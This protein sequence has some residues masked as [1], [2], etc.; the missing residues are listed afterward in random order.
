VDRAKIL[1]AVKKVMP[2]ALD[3]IQRRL[4]AVQDVIY[5]GNELGP[6]TIKQAGRAYYPG[7]S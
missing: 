7:T 1:D 5:F 4:S 3:P 6:D 2:S